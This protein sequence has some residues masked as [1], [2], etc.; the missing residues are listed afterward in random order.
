MQNFLS[1]FSLAFGILMFCIH[2]NRVNAVCAFRDREVSVAASFPL[3]QQGNA[4]HVAKCR[5][6]WSSFHCHASL[7]KEPHGSQLWTALES[8]FPVAPWPFGPRTWEASSGPMATKS[9]RIPGVTAWQVQLM[10]SA[11]GKLN[12]LRLLCTST[13]QTLA[14][15]GRC[16]WQDSFCAGNYSAQ[17]ILKNAKWILGMCI[18]QRDRLEGRDKALTQLTVDCLFH[19]SKQAWG[20]FHSMFV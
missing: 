7:R 1:W 17:L 4:W 10:I 2:A 18:P 14:I 8:W 16:P 12:G 3:I 5:I 13:A 20:G 6:I 9:S 11:V 15:S 19:V